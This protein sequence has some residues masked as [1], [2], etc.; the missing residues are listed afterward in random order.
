[1]SLTQPATTPITQPE[2]PAPVTLP[3]TSTPTASLPR[4]VSS[5]YDS[6]SASDS[7]ANF[8]PS[9]PP[10]TASPTLMELQPTSPDVSDIE[11]HP[12]ISFIHPSLHEESN[13]EPTT[14][15]PDEI[16]P[17]SDE[18]EFTII[19]GGSKCGGDVLQETVPCLLPTSRPMCD[20]KEKSAHSLQDRPLRKKQYTDTCQLIH[21]CPACQ[22]CHLLFAP[23]IIYTRQKRPKQ[24]KDLNFTWVTEELPD[25]F[26]QHDMVVGSARH[27][28]MFASL[29]LSLLSKAKTWYV[30]ATFEA[31]Q[32]P[33]Q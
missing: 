30:D 2:T 7:N 16:L 12:V 20:N 22:R 6:S 4:L 17:E 13:L 31:V 29:L 21:L 23:P 15:I 5:M 14:P 8:F 3:S 32:R 25:N 24:P 27:V 33:F 11:D 26:V 18:E 1:M 9:S 10:P 19:V 28:I